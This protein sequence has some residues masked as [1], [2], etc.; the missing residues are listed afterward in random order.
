MANVRI[1]LIGGPTVLIEYGG[2][3]ILTDPTFDPP[4][5]YKMGYTTLTKSIGPALSAEAI[6]PVDAVLVSHDQHKDNLDHAG[7]EYLLRAPHAFTTKIGA[8]RIG[9]KIVGLAPWETA[10]VRNTAGK[11][12]TITATPARHGPAGIEPLA[13]DVIGFVLQTD[14]LPPVYATGDTTWFDGTE[15]V[16]R[17]FDARVVFPV[18]GAAQTRGPFNITMNTND[19]IATARHFPRAAIVPVHSDSW[20]HFT[21]TRADIAK[22]FDALGIGKRLTL[23]EPGVPAEVAL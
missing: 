19:G 2:F 23:L 11:T 14:D 7:S 6:G 22:S 4:G 5:D 21:Q 1:T 8:E 9:G 15:E 13:G 20:A 10:T 16:A 17:R 3:R 18:A 12:L